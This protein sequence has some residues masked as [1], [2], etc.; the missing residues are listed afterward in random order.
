M[1]IFAYLPIGSD[2]TPI[3]RRELVRLLGCDDREVRRQIEKAKDIVPVINV[4]D[5]Y[6]IPDDP[7]DPNLKTYIISE[8]RRAKKI[9]KGI[10]KCKWLYGINTKQ[11]TLEI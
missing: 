6:Y 10:K 7:D 4:G 2:S 1:N 5:G 8:T 11:E 9:F 3:K